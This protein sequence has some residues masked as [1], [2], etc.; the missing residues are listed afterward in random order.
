MAIN[1][2]PAVA[3]PVKS[4]QRGSAGGSGS[5]TV[6]SINPAKSTLQV[7]GTASTGTVSASFNMSMNA[8]TT[9]A[10]GEVGFNSNNFGDQRIPYPGSST[11]W[12]Q[13]AP[14]NSATPT[15]SAASTNIWVLT[16][17]VNSGNASVG[18][19]STN[20]VAA[21]VSGYISDATTI[22]VTGACRWELVEYN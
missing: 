22:V 15:R 18:A 4:I 3:S 20:L 6:T 19:G 11:G 14:Q 12:A 5:I 2:Y 16:T 7:F 17:P 9:T 21:V 1:T 13:T 10:F 8:G